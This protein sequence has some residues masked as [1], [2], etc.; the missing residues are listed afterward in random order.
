[1][2]AASSKTEYMS[3]NEFLEKELAASSI[4]SP[5]SSD[6]NKA[7]V[8]FVDLSTGRS[9][10]G[11][12]GR[13]TIENEDMNDGPMLKVIE[14]WNELL[15]E[16]SDMLHMGA[17]GLDADKLEDDPLQ[18]SS[19]NLM[20]QPLIPQM[21]I[22]K[23]LTL[24]KS[25]FTSGNS[26]AHQVRDIINSALGLIKDCHEIFASLR[27]TEAFWII[28][29][30]MASVLAKLGLGLEGLIQDAQLLDLIHPVSQTR[31]TVKNFLKTI[32]KIKAKHAKG[33]K[34]TVKTMEALK[35]SL[36]NL[37]ND[38]KIFINFFYACKHLNQHAYFTGAG[39]LINRLDLVA[40]AGI[41]SVNRLLS[42]SS[43][44][45]IRIELNLH[46]AFIEDCK[47]TI[48]YLESFVSEVSLVALD[49]GFPETRRKALNSFKESF[50]AFQEAFERTKEE[51]LAILDQEGQEILSAS[52]L[53][54]FHSTGLKEK[55]LKAVDSSTEMIKLLEDSISGSWNPS[56]HSKSKEHDS[57]NGFIETMKDV[58]EERKKE[59]HDFFVDR[60]KDSNSYL[61]S[62]AVE[63]YSTSNSSKKEEIEFLVDV[64]RALDEVL[65]KLETKR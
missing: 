54:I 2:G 57:G 8:E 24:R 19:L 33:E 15:I 28:A 42:A 26:R 52:L 20:E 61:K 11:H 9:G 7:Q 43:E 45:E 48:S 65:A 63:M 18:G 29:D 49:K 35:N 64:N 41:P 44:N 37:S 56:T 21:N 53:E 27:E 6:K 23:T 25:N 38:A 36:K 40:S 34:N 59:V 39:H 12:G 4:N 17:N 50:K 14:L 13:A 3:I 62:K 58:K 1:M 5:F 10:L 32:E 47:K 22:G 55:M 46:S 31:K 30:E 51:T 16:Q 60:F